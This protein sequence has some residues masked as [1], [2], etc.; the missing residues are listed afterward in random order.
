MARNGYTEEEAMNRIKAQIPIEEK[1]SKTSVE[2][3]NSGSLE[4]TKVQV[5]EISEALSRHRNSLIGYMIGFWPA[6]FGYI[7]I[8]TM[9]RS[10]YMYITRYKRRD[11]YKKLK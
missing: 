2:V 1:R 10:Y 8:R 9:Q 7:L 4:N 3:D 6:V 5:E 11:L